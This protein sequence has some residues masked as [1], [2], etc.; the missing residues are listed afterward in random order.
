METKLMIYARTSYD[1]NFNFPEARFLEYQSNFKY[2]WYDMS[3]YTL[4]A[5]LN[6]CQEHKILILQLEATTPH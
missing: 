2:A 5:I 4:Q 6:G 3:S 1:L